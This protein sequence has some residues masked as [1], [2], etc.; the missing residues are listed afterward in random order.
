MLAK[1]GGG[2][3]FVCVY[4]ERGRGNLFERSG[5]TMGDGNNPSFS[6]WHNVPAPS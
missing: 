2:V 1:G 5:F 4:E 3:S 6:A